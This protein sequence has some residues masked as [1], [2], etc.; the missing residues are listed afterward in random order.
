MNVIFIEMFSNANISKNI[1]L[2]VMIATFV[3][4]NIWRR[5]RRSKDTVSGVDDGDEEEVESRNGEELDV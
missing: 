4:I 5:R 1:L 2:S 3:I